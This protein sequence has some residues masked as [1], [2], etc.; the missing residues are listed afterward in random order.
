LNTARVEAYIDQLNT[1]EPFKALFRQ[2]GVRYSWL[3]MFTIMLAMLATLL[4]GTIIN[5]AI[6]EIMGTYGIGQDQA[7][8]LSTANLAAATVGMLTSSWLV[9]SFGL[10]SALLGMMSLFL[11]SSIVGGLSPNLEVMI[12]ARIVQ[13]LTSGQVAPLSITIIFQLFPYGKQGV[14]MGISSIGAV[15]APAIGPTVGGVIIDNLSWHYVFYLG[16]P[17]SLLCMPMTMLFLPNRPGPRPALPF[18]WWGLIALSIAITT[19]LMALTNGEKDGWDSNYVLSLFAIS[20]TAWLGFIEW[21]RR[22][23]TP[24]LNLKIFTIR[25]FS[26]FALTAFAVGGGLYGSMYLIPLFLQLVQ[27][28]SPR[29]AGYAM[30]PA[31]IALA[32][33]VPACGRLVDKYDPRILISL[34]VLLISLSFYLMRSAD[35]ATGF[36]LFAWWMILGR[37]GIALSFPSLSLGAVKSVPSEFISEASGVLNFTRQLGGAFGVNLLSIMLL[38][39]TRFH[40]DALNATQTFDNSSTAEMLALI[41]QQLHSAGVTALEQGALAMQYLAGSIAMQASIIAFQDCFEISAIV[42]LLTLIPTWR[43]KRESAL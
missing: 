17:F 41:Q 40:T 5:V 2:Y 14:A 29:E 37:I 34:G 22:F 20:G 32:I 16:V 7:Q 24:L 21:Q 1:S 10:R 33:S 27:G 8:W 30:L 19:L 12:L 11:L 15:L 3:A 23:P 43:L 39:R 4:T 38:R 28:M 35:A 6:P 31:G 18:D 42:F 13:G 9:Q 26:V 25:R 36:W